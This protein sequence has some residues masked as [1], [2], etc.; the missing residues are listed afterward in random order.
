MTSLLSLALV[1]S[2]PALQPRQTGDAG[3]VHQSHSSDTI[4]LS[5]EATGMRPPMTS[6]EEKGGVSRRDTSPHRTLQKSSCVRGGGPAWEHSF[7]S[8]ILLL[9]LLLL[10]CIFKSS[11]LR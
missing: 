6:Q 2:A 11:G 5:D 3:C 7:C 1:P 8:S 10:M 9:I 4:T